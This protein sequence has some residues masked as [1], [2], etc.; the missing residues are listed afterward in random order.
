MLK[1]F[2]M[3]AEGYTQKHKSSCFSPHLEFLYFFFFF[4]HD[5]INTFTI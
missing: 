4:K 5:T 2:A 3:K 1:L